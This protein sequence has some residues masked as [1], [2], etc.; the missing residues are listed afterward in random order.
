MGGDPRASRSL[1]PPILLSP[2]LADRRA[3]ERG[4]VGIVD[5]AIEDLTGI[6]ALSYLRADIERNGPAASNAACPHNT[7]CSHYEMPVEITTKRKKLRCS[8]RAAREPA[9][10]SKRCPQIARYLVAIEL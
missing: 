9:V 2:D 4:P 6:G 1:P 5:P 8:L 3:F 7:L 10:T